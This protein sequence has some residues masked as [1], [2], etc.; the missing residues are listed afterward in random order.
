MMNISNY[1]PDINTLHLSEHPGTQPA[2]RN[3]QP[4]RN[5]Q[6]PGNGSVFINRQR[7][8]LSAINTSGFVSSFRTRAEQQITHRN[9]LAIPVSYAEKLLRGEIKDIANI[10]TQDMQQI[11]ASELNNYPEKMQQIQQ[12]TLEHLATLSGTESSDI[13]NALLTYQD[14]YGDNFLMNIAS[15]GYT[16]LEDYLRAQDEKYN[17][18]E[19]IE[20][21]LHEF[22]DNYDNN[23]IMDNLG[24]RYSLGRL[25]N[26]LTGTTKTLDHFLH[27]AP[28]LND[29][30]LLKGSAG[31]NNSLSTQVDGNLLVK[32]LLQGQGLRFNSFLSTTSNYD[33]ACRFCSSELGAA[34]YSIDLT[35]TSD[36]SEALRRKMLHDLASPDS[37]TE[38]ILYFFK[39]TNVAGISISTLK[40]ALESDSVNKK[41]D[42][43]DEILLAPGHYF[44]PEKIVRLQH[45]VAI[46]GALAYG[47][48]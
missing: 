46:T 18:P 2:M 20:D 4:G 23:I 47:R 5:I 7:T 17:D 36:E 40:N 25:E 42:N 12:K 31:L 22:N 15:M 21:F 34:L 19:E 44:I 8:E 48:E 1:N 26:E 29:I 32:S 35:G 37:V 6:Q 16:K 24:L 33:V 11:V 27:T 28:R 38:N 3:T 45:G 13:Y 43:E 9:K 39:A 41:L 14:V 30:P 10:A